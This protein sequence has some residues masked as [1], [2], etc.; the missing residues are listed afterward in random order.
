LPMTRFKIVEKKSLL[1]S[2]L[3][4]SFSQIDGEARRHQ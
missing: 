4:R 3:M 2:A 1:N